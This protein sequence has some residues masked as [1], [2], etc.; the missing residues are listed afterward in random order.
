MVKKKIKI[1]KDYIRRKT[2]VKTEIKR[3]IL[4]SILQNFQST[5][6]VRLNSFKKIQFLNKKGYLSKQNNLCL[7]TGKF[8]GIFKKFGF[9]RHMIKNLAKNNLL[10]NVKIKSW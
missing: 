2:F 1:Y 7:Y 4:K 9:S 3:I 6:L 10:H 8:G 5:N